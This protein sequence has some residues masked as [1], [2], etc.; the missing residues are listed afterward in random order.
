MRRVRFGA[1]AL[2]EQHWRTR[3]RPKVALTE[4]GAVLAAA[5]MERR[6]GQPF[7]WYRCSVC[8]DY[9]V[10]RASL[11]VDLRRR[12]P[13]GSPVAFVVY[14]PGEM[15]PDRWVVM[16]PADADLDDRAL[17][18]STWDGTEVRYERVVGGQP[19][20]SAPVPA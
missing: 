14:R 10:G 3:G 7:R 11:A 1:R 20:G 18:P 5:A 15:D 4:L 12:R 6:L 2:R 9:H 17:Y 19:L 13:D 8:G 16:V